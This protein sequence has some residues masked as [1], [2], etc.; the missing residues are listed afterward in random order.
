MTRIGVMHLTDT[1]DAGGLERVAVN[2]VNL[3][4][5][6]CFRPFLC[7]TRRDGILNELIEEDVGRISLGRNRRFDVSAIVRLAGFIEKHEIK[8]LHA[9]GSALLIAVLAS[10]LPPFPKVIWHNH[11]GAL[12]TK[13][14]SAFPYWLLARRV[15]I[16]LAVNE[17]LEAWSRRRLGM[18]AERVLFLRN[19]ICDG[20]ADDPAPDLPGTK[21]KRIVCVANLRPQKDHLSLVRALAVVVN[22]L[23]EAVLLLIGATTDSFQVQ[24]VKEEIARYGLNDNVHILGS[25][26]DVPEILAGCDVGVLSSA[27]EGL[28]LSLIE[29]GMAG[30]ATVATNVGQC[31]EV[32]DNG[33]VGVLVESGRPELLARALLDRL[34]DSSGSKFLGESFRRYVRH[35]YGPDESMRKVIEIYERLCGDPDGF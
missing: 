33:R 10:L 30:L 17:E 13:K 7:T 21:G 8:I 29:Y 19:F 35:K 34:E 5:R 20:L 24:A 3:L 31:A 28:P 9:H 12:A 25:R 11:Y 14:R 16:V 6:D 2:F 18:P 15:S 22:A 27:S 26:Q 1:L 23:P 32:L 4:P